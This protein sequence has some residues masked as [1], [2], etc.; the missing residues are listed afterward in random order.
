[1]ATIQTYVSQLYSRQVKVSR[2]FG[3]DI[4]RA[5]KQTR[6]ANK[7]TLV[8]LAVIVKTLV[9]AGVVTDAQFVATLDAAGNALDYEDE[10]IV[11]TPVEG[12]A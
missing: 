1:M 8:L 10:P 7:S 2:R 12:G 4:S 3:S 11:T 5:S 9:D 6:V